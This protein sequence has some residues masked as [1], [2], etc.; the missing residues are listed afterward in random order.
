MKLHF[1]TMHTIFACVG[2]SVYWCDLDSKYL[3][4]CWQMAG[5]F[6]FTIVYLYNNLTP[7]CMEITLPRH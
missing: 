6:I 2:A 5:F 4:Q 7:M 3:F 1:C